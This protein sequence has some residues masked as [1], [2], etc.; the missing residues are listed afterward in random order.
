MR[1]YIVQHING[2]NFPA[3]FQ[4]FSRPE[5]AQDQ[6]IVWKGRECPNSTVISALICNDFRI[7]FGTKIESKLPAG[8]SA[9]SRVL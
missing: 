2:L 6:L 9:S 5:A 7:L 4:L 8:T 1:A 3:I